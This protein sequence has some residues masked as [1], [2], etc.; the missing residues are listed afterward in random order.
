MRVCEF[1]YFNRTALV[2]SLTYS[3]VGPTTMGRIDTGCARSWLRVKVRGSMSYCRKGGAATA[4]INFV[5]TNG[6]PKAP[7]FSPAAQPLRGRAIIK[8]NF[9]Q[10]RDSVMNQWSTTEKIN[11]CLLYSRR[12]M[13]N[14]GHEHPLRARRLFWY[15]S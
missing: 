14:Y 4:G 12:T 1:R 5:T 10:Y 2:H 6:P 8:D 11:M 15:S 13:L 9:K 7:F 3:I